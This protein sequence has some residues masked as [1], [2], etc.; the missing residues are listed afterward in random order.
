MRFGI[1][2]LIFVALMLGLLASTWIFVF[3]K[4]DARRASK[5][6]DID[7]W[8]KQLT[9]LRRA[10]SGIDDMGRKIAELQRAI[11]FFASKL[12]AA[13]EMDKVLTEVSQ[14]ADANSLQSKT[15]KSLKTER[16]SSYSEQS[17]QMSLSGDFNG[18]YSFLLQLEKLPRI[19]RVT[20]M[21]LQ[22][23][24]DRDGEMQAQLTLS[25][26]FEPDTGAT[27][28]DRPATATAA[29]RVASTK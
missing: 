23:I 26:F 18:F 15:V 12:P 14:M 13:K 28:T 24:N 1:R 21:N 6:N 2:E 4:A 5:L 29:N 10:S 22:K 17:I 16:G 25:I 11:D 20:N 9:N 7:Q 8:D 19:T 3:K 27:G